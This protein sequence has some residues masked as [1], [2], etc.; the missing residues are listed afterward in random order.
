MT[1]VRHLLYSPVLA[2]LEPDARSR[3]ARMATT[4]SLTP[5]QTLVLAGEP[6]DHVYLVTE[7][8]LKLIAFVQE[9]EQV[10]DIACPGDLVCDAE[11]LLDVPPSLDVV[12]ATDAR[13]IA[14]ER[15]VFIDTLD[16]KAR[17]ELA[18]SLSR[19]AIRAR[20]SAA[21]SSL[22]SVGERAAARLL[23]LGDALGRMR[24]DAIEIELPLTQA[25]LG[26]LAGTSRESMCRTI[27][28][29]K[30][31]GLIEARG[32]KLRIL[33]PDLLERLRCG[34]RASIPSR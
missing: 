3:L 25:E 7:G 15:S 2:A 28:S 8:V 12:G 17:L 31:R 4:R 13:V 9:R 19:H 10:V 14:F 29:F 6:S 1:S 22:R 20:F 24:T 21:D 27:N 30:R 23:E 16:A 18:R 33:R 5:G 26:Q 32:R 11:A 34:E